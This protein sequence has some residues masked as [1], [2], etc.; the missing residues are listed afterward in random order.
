MLS[1]RIV[2]LRSVVTAADVSTGQEKDQVEWPPHPD[3]FFSTLVQAWGDLNE[4]EDG[5]EAL[6][7]LEKAGPPWIRAGE[8]LS[9]NTVTRYVPVNDQPVGKGI[10]QGTGLTRERKARVIPQGALSEPEVIL[11]WPDFRPSPEIQKALKRLAAQ[12]SHLGHSSSF[13]QV[14]LLDTLPETGQIWKPDPDGPRAFRVPYPGRLKELIASY[15]LRKK[16]LSWPPVGLHVNYGRSPEQKPLGAGAHGEILPFRLRRDGQPLPLE[17]SA[18]VLAVWRKALMQATPQP[19]PEILSGHA[20][21][22]TPENPLPSRGPHLAL[23]PLPDVGHPY[24]RGHL[25]G[26]AAVLPREAAWTDRAACQGALAAVERLTLGDL[27]VVRL[28]PVDAFETR[29]ALQPATWSRAA[30]VWGSVTP[31]VLG[32]F[33]GRLFSEETSRIVAEACSIAGLPAPARI[34]IAGVPWILGSVPAARFPL[35]PARPGKPRRVHVHVRLEF[36]ELVRGPV[37]VGAGRHVG[38]GLFRQLEDR[39]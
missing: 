7:A 24:A 18:R 23:I 28:E 11:Y 17:C 37:L 34:D 10:V 35:L 15:R 9:S 4:P 38:Y 6:L 2:Y 29:R 21:E 12:V 39:H 20:P 1:F 3:R 14:V 33:P 30:R 13:V 36:E 22:S 27:G 25:L 19:V 31:V 8:L 16:T 26:V 5:R 32:K